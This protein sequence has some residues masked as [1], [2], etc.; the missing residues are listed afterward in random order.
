MTRAEVDGLKTAL[1]AGWPPPGRAVGGCGCPS[2]G[3]FELPTIAWKQ[4]G[5]S[6]LI[7]VG[8]GYVL[9]ARK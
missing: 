1:R 9:F 4:V 8:L 7:G 5:V 6:V 2:I 3:A